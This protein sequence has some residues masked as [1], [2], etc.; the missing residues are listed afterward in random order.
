MCI[1]KK[2]RKIPKKGNYCASCI[3]NRFKNRHPEKYA[4]FILKNNAKRRGKIFEI[5]FE[6]FL[7]FC[8]KH[9]YIAR[10]GITKFGLHI[11]RINESIG[12]IEGNLQ[13]L[14]NTENVKKFIQYNFDKN[15]KPTDFVIKKQINYFLNKDPF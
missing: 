10:K 4:Y 14:T 5:S 7:K 3:I 6:Y 1:T 11:D 15:G 2:C 13:V 9:Q 8:K 12:Y